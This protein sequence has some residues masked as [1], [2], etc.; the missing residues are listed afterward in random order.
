[1]TTKE[2]IW[3]AQNEI[4]EKARIGSKTYKGYFKTL[5]E[6]KLIERKNDGR[7]VY[8]ILHPSFIKKEMKP[9]EK[10]L[11]EEVKDAFGHNK[12]DNSPT[13]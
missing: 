7:F 5:E 6:R 12:E 2:F 9:F 3:T 8:Y 10:E 1:M 4:I 11:Q 13:S